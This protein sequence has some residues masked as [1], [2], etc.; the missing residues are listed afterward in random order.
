MDEFD[1]DNDDDLV[2][3]IVIAFGPK[4]EHY[5][6]VTVYDDCELWSFYSLGDPLVFYQLNSIQ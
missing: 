3:R 5:I 1:A 6:W 2:Q 4:A